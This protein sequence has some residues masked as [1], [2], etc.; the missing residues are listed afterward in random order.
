[1]SKLFLDKVVVRFAG[2]SGDGIQLIGNQFSDSSVIKSGNDVYTFVDYP[3]EIRAPAGSMSGVS[4][5]QVTISSEKIF[6][7][8]NKIDSLVVF[9]PAAL[10]I[11]LNMLKDGGLLIV[12]SDSFND[13]NL[14]KAG[15]NSNPL[16]DDFLSKFNFLVSL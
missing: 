3:S 4:G 8:D 6:S 10:K 5:F 2:D 1:M 14:K 9:N 7:F 11:S 13:K 16:N 12:D 15:Y